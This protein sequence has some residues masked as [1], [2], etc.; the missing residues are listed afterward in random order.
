MLY[1]FLQLSSHSDH[2]PSQCTVGTV[3]GIV[4]GSGVGGMVVLGGRV[5]GAGVGGDVGGL[6]SPSPAAH[7][8][9]T[10][11]ARSHSSP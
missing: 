7:C 5:V 10:E 2:V 1:V 6:Q 9:T 3:G 4:V 11:V 8:S